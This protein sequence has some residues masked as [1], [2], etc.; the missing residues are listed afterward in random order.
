MSSGATTTGKITAKSLPK[1]SGGGGKPGAA[2]V[3]HAQEEEAD[4]EF[5]DEEAFSHLVELG[6]SDGPAAAPVFK[7]PMVPAVI[8]S[9]DDKT[10]R[11][12]VSAV[13]DDGAGAIA[14]DE[15]AGEAK[16]GE[17]ALAGTP[18]SRAMFD[19]REDDPLA[20]SSI[21]WLLVLE[22]SFSAKLCSLLS[23]V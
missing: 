1:V 12:E 10:K 4:D 7:I 23:A 18:G 17:G 16:T 13:D 20:A 5:Y 22:L 11:E 3:P 14:P 9:S 6:S 8:S 2:G 19:V 21:A 15:R